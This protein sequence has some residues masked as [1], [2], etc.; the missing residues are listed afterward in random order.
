MNCGDVDVEVEFGNGADMLQ[1]ECTNSGLFATEATSS[2]ACNLDRRGMERGKRTE[3]E[4]QRDRE[5][6]K[7]VGKREK[8][9]SLRIVVICHESLKRGRS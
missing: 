8:V 1:V 2:C 3:G 6:Q 9:R 5:R 7:N 4:R